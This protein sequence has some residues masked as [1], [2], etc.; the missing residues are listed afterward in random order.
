MAPCSRMILCCTRLLKHYCF[1]SFCDHKLSCYWCK[2]GWVT[3]LVTD[4]FSLLFKGVSCHISSNENEGK[5]SHNLRV[6][7]CFL[8]RLFMAI[9]S[10]Q[11]SQSIKC[12]GTKTI[13][14][15]YMMSCGMSEHCLK[16]DFPHYVHTNY[17][18][19][20]SI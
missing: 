10:S 3:V 2:I 15:T 6:K 1:L 5:I 12:V 19:P 8:G 17:W 20:T 9:L 16:L 14:T 13:R 18:Q 4:M 11:F 7:A